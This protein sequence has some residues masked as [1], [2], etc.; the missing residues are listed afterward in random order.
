M[1]SDEIRTCAA[2]SYYD[3]AALA[4]AVWSPFVD[5]AES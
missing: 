4:E 1:I 5:L 2:K 3:R